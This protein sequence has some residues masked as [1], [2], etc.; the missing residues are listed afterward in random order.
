MKE[1]CLLPLFP[2]VV[3]LLIFHR[4]KEWR[5][6]AV[7]LSAMTWARFFTERALELE[8]LWLNTAKLPHTSTS[9]ATQG[10]T[11]PPQCLDFYFSQ[12]NRIF[13]V[14]R[15]PKASPSPTLKWTALTGAEST[16]LALSA[17][18]SD[19]C[20]QSCTKSCP[21]KFLLSFT[22]VQSFLAEEKS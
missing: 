21:L 9:T 22:A 16:T 13:W 19:Q 20:S 18:C 5:S 4:M 15:N 10:Q 3:W 2:W 17:P 14:G 8:G 12:H 6:R 7:D 1:W 11:G